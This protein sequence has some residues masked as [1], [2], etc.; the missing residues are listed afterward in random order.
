MHVRIDAR[1]YDA[2]IYDP[3]SLTLMHVRIVLYVPMILDPDI[4]MY[5]ACMYDAYISVILDPDAC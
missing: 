5:Y 2:H 4:C 1:M 3:Y